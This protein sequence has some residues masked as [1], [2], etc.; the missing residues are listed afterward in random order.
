M[1]PRID[2]SG[3]AQ[4]SG[5][6][7]LRK[8]TEAPKEKL[9]AAASEGVKKGMG[10]SGS[11]KAEKNGAPLNGGSILRTVV[12]MSI[13]SFSPGA[14]VSSV[15]AKQNV[16][17]KNPNLQNASLASQIQKNTQNGTAGKTAQNSKS[18]GSKGKEI[19]LKGA[20][21]E[22]IKNC[23]PEQAKNLSEAQLKTL[24]HGD[25]FN[26]SPKALQSLDVCKLNVTCVNNLLQSDQ[27][28]HLSLNQLKD[29]KA[30]QDGPNYMSHPLAA[31]SA[32]A[33]FNLEEVLDKKL[34]E[35][36]KSE[37][38]HETSEAAK[39]PESS[40]TEQA[41]VKSAESEKPKESEAKAPP[42]PETKVLESLK[43]AID[44][45]DDKTKLRMTSKEGSEPSYEAKPRSAASQFS[46]RNVGTDKESLATVSD[47]LSK[48]KGLSK[49][50]DA[51]IAKEA[52]GLLAKLQQNE[53]ASKTIKHNEIMLDSKMEEKL[54]SDLK[55]Q[56]P[57]E[58]EISKKL[59]TT[60]KELQSGDRNREG[61]VGKSESIQGDFRMYDTA[62]SPEFKR[63]IMKE[64]MKFESDL[65][66]GNSDLKIKEAKKAEIARIKA[67]AEAAANTPE[68]LAEAK[69]KAEVQAKAKA[70][71]KALQLESATSA[72]LSNLGNP[73]IQETIIY[74]SRTFMTSEQLFSGL[75][76]SYKNLGTSAEQKD[77]IV[78]FTNK[79]LNTSNVSDLK[80]ENVAKK[81]TEF[82]NMVNADMNKEVISV[83]VPQSIVS[84][85]SVKSFAQLKESSNNDPKSIAK[86]LAKTIAV[87]SLEVSID[88]IVRNENG[89]SLANNPV[90]NLANLQN[91]IIGSVL[92]DILSSKSEAEATSK[93]NLYYRVGFEAKEA[94]DTALAITMLT[95]LEKT[96]LIRLNL[97]NE[98][99]IATRVNSEGKTQEL[100][101]KDIHAELF[102]LSNHNNHGKYL[103][104]NPG[105][106]HFI[107]NALP[108][109][110]ASKENA[111]FVKNNE[112]KELQGKEAQFDMGTMEV[113]ESVF[114][115][116]E[117]RQNKLRE[118]DLSNSLNLD[119]LPELNEKALDDRSK[120][121]K[122][123][124]EAK[125]QF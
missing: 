70:E 64:M 1:N 33:S 123:S 39:T 125:M 67:E 94:G 16:E 102:P 121:I 37:A 66:I 62:I 116:I 59:I 24:A 113:F 93:M 42:S 119:S 117:G 98:T 124:R 88:S 7:Q 105:A 5:E 22:A 92:D 58:Q 122:A 120:L 28:H 79:W 47:M 35:A 95:A 81:V 71:A 8:S 84:T 23:T 34:A 91:K 106:K 18:E 50:A 74:G 51:E 21:E 60:R 61:A 9:N 104:S 48:L 110:I 76:K 54:I 114:T 68:A 107:Q 32:D 75:E 49:S 72:L 96:Y 4:R 13:N 43:K 87:A 83:K 15:W 40:V 6:I 63:N 25:I 29:L 82:A 99:V 85:S 97:N 111:Q 109:Y 103:E 10:T 89:T 26:L 55:P 57:Y 2:R 12:R 20:T 108:Q 65:I 38:A 73:K 17:V 27:I 112:G 19:K 78:Q 14:V 41:S 77:E 115:M 36:P 101:G 44:Q 90:Q 3:D 45:L 46:T 86:E 118:S 11:A 100:T 69:L 80:Q 56:N 52:N 31:M 30:T 53:W